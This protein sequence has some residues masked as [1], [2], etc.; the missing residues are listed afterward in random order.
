M[1][2][3]DILLG[4]FVAFATALLSYSRKAA[5]RFTRTIDVPDGPPAGWFSGSV[6]RGN[7]RWHT[8]V[9]PS[10]P[11]DR[12]G[13]HGPAN[14]GRATPPAALAQRA[15]PDDPRSGDEFRR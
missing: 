6:R 11:A 13:G 1:I 2:A 3:V 5:G 4:G 10:C 12:N 9:G 14:T 8:E 7:E 15:G